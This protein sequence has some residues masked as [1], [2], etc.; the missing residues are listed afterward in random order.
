MLARVLARVASGAAT[1]LH[2]LD[3]LDV[4]L[5]LFLNALRNNTC[6]AILHD[7]VCMWVAA[8][9]GGVDMLLAL[10]GIIDAD[11]TDAGGQPSAPPSATAQQAQHGLAKCIKNVCV[12]LREEHNALLVA[13][14][15][16]T[17]SPLERHALARVPLERG[18]PLERVPIE[19][20]PHDRP[21]PAAR[22]LTQVRAWQVQPSG[23]DC[24]LPVEPRV[25]PVAAASRSRQQPRHRH[26]HRRALTSPPSPNHRR[27]RRQS[28]RAA[29]ADAA[30]VTRTIPTGYDLLNGI[31][32]S[33]VELLLPRRFFLR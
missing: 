33:G 8:V 30:I 19:R 26:R 15:L 3:Q 12:L 21:R 10:R 11:N 28:P 20:K 1:H 7:C 22:V 24:P 17:R 25:P 32:T 16:L 27:C 29:A 4:L 13:P 31:C 2:V 23:P 9:G 18:P 6:C 5:H 14:P